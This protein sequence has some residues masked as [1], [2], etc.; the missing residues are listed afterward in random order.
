MV[1]DGYLVVDESSASLSEPPPSRLTRPSQL[2]EGGDRSILVCS[3]ADSTPPQCARSTGV[4][5]APRRRRA[6]TFGRGSSSTARRPLAATSGVSDGHFPST[7]AG[8]ATSSIVDELHGRCAHCFPLSMSTLHLS[9][10]LYPVSAR[11]LAARPLLTTLLRLS[12]RF[13]FDDFG[14]CPSSSPH[15]KPP[16]NLPT[17]SIDVVRTVVDR[18]DVF[19]LL[20]RK[21]RRLVVMY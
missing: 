10:I 13:F 21:P 17:L 9:L 12:S 1:L 15:S 11:P 6:R 7:P 14:L 18:V 4:L 20:G 2:A 16:L 5:P 3:L 8:V 19:R